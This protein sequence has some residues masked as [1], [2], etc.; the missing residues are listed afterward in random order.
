MCYNYMSCG[1]G[2]VS[3]APQ[4]HTT[5]SRISPVTMLRYG[6]ST[7][8]QSGCSIATTREGRIAIT[9]KPSSHQNS[10][11]Q[12]WRSK[13]HGPV[14]AGCKLGW[15]VGCNARNGRKEDSSQRGQSM[16]R[17]SQCRV[18]QGQGSESH[19]PVALGGRV[20]D[21]DPDETFVNFHAW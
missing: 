11:L 17:D 20:V 12:F 10:P 18:T 21:E 1:A 4:R 15:R 7:K 13:N 19:D 3:S 2:K 8:L 6:C 14:P 9:I 5:S 16:A